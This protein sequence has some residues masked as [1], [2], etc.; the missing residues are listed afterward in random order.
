VWKN[1]IN[2]YYCNAK[3][4]IMSTKKTTSDYIEF[5][6]ASRI[7]KEL[8][9][10][11]KT[12]NLGLYI[13]F[14]INTG[15]RCGD[16]LTLKWNLFDNEINQIKII[17]GKTKK[18]RIISI[19][20]NLLELQKY[21]IGS[22]FIF[23]SQKESVFSIQQLNR[24]LKQVFKNESRNYNIST[25]SLRKSFGR[26]CYDLMNQSEHALTLLSDTFQHTSVKVTRRYLGLRD[27]EIQNLYSLIAK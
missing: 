25:H 2:D 1:T 19:N 20:A 24:L 22:G 16:L 6:K 23:T 10:N 26:H 9:K 11:P 5:D 17:E 4:N 15:L 14:S 21:R 27:L 18:E 3:P 8:L 7:G 13:L 12:K